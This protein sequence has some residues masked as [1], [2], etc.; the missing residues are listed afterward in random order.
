[1]KQVATAVIAELRAIASEG[2][3][4]SQ[5]AHAKRDLANKTALPVEKMAPAARLVGEA[6][7]HGRS[8]SDAQ[9]WRRRIRDMSSQEIK[10]AALTL[11]QGHSVSGV[12]APK[13]RP[14]TGDRRLDEWVCGRTLDPLV[15]T[16][17][18]IA[19]VVRSRSCVITS[20][21]WRDGWMVDG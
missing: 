10:Q 20:C 12:L 11:L 9:N 17:F 1:M 16:G 19:H 14:P 18:Q 13:N 7:M 15:A 3:S 6:L 2:I 8:L 5:L 4:E 21:T